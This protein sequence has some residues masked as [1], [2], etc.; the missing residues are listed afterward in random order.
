MVRRGQL[1]DLEMKHAQHGGIKPRSLPFTN[2]HY[3]RVPETASIEEQKTPNTEGDW[4]VFE[5]SHNSRAYPATKVVELATAMRAAVLHFTDDPI[6]EGISG[7]RLDGKPSVLPHVAFLPLPY[8]GFKHADGR[9][10]GIAVSLPSAMGNSSRRALLRALGAWEAEVSLPGKQSTWHGEAPLRLVLGA[11]GVIR[12]IRLRRPSG[13][14]SLRPSVW[15][16]SSRQ[17]VSA[18]PIALPSHPGSLAKG[19][20]TARAKAWAAAE[21]AVRAACEHVGLPEPTSVEVSLNPYILG[22]RSTTHYPAFRQRGRNGT[23]LSRQLVHASLTFEHPSERT[24]DVGSRQ[25]LWIG[26]DAARHKVR[27]GQFS[28]G[29]H[30]WMNSISAAFRKLRR[31]NW[32]KALSRS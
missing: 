30:G 27:S 4:F 21:A 24:N 13:L 31:R 5:F 7:H 14:V 22:A 29:K 15:S 26:F 28:S 1:A 11:G 3:R 25:V 10:L 23:Q 17:W 19:T 16:R 8:V 2:A 20:S 18:T 6:P 9:I 12:M 32:S